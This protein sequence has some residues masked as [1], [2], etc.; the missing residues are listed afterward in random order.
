MKRILFIVIAAAILSGAVGAETLT[1]T[2]DQAVELAIAQNLGLKQSGIDLRTKQRSKDTAWNAFLPSMSV[3][4]G[5]NGTSGIFQFQG[6]AAPALTDP[7]NF[8]FTTGVSLALPINAAVGTGIKNLVAEFEAGQLSYE[9]AQKELERD[10]R[11]QFHL[12]LGSLENIKI[13]EANIDLA[14]NRLDQAR[15]NFNNGLAPELEVLTSEVTVSNLQPAY[16]GVVNGYESLML[17]FKFLLGV[18]RQT[19]LVLEGNLDTELYDL[20]SEEL[21]NKYIARRLDIRGLDKQVEALEYSRKTVNRNFN[22]PTLNLGYSY[23]LS[24]TNADQSFTTGLP[25]EPWS[26]WNDRGALSLGLQWKFDGLIPGS[27][28]NVQVKGIQDGIDALNIAR[29]MAFQNAGIEITNLVNALDTARKTI[30]ANR[31]SVDLARRNYE[32]TEEAYNVGTRELLDV[33]SAQNDYLAAAQQLL[34]ARYEYIAGLLDL[35]YALNASMDEF[36]NN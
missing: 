33:Q 29:E 27:K 5:F 19:E 14:Q 24:G 34:L 16:N 2:V 21:I 22:T 1:L 26:D 3:S 25:I 28:T 30:E 7:G 10:V 17:F 6:Q 18:D 11:K 20:N 12:L 4:A 13:Q 15:N 35:E 9:A 23:S 32:L 8:G 31:S 36:L